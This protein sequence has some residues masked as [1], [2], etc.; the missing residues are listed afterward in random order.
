MS[1][2]IE[3]KELLESVTF[4]TSKGGKMVVIQADV[5]ERIVRKANK[6]LQQQEHILALET[7]IIKLRERVNEL[8]E[9]R[10]AEFARKKNHGPRKRERER[11]RYSKTGQAPNYYMRQQAEK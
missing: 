11:N 6:D 9:M 1:E 10:W 2:S 8:E 7:E 4:E 3:Y 5:L